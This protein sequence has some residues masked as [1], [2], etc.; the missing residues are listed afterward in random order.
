MIFRRFLKYDSFKMCN[1]C[2]FLFV[3]EHIS[4]GNQVDGEHG[5]KGCLCFGRAP[6]LCGCVVSIFWMLLCF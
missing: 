6:G 5:G 3:R 1:V 2:I 4:L